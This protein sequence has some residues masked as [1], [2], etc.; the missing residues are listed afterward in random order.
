MGAPEITSVAPASR[1]AAAGADERLVHDLHG[2]LTVIRGLCATLARGAPR[3]DR[4]RD[5]ALIDAE[6]LRLAA[7]LEGL[8]RRVA[9]PARERR[10]ALALEALAVSV[11]ERHHGV[12]AQRGAL[13]SVRRHRGHPVVEADP[14]GLRR[15]LDNLVQ[16]ALRH[17]AREVRIVVG[18]RGDLA[19]VLV[20]DD[21]PG[22]RPEDRERIF[23]PRDRGS[24]PMGP[25]RGLGLAIA[26]EIARAHGG[27]LTLDPVGPGASFRLTLPLCG[28]PVTEP[29]AA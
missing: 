4:R 26:R 8:A 14:A 22:V 18:V 15:V 17:C 28:G 13:L 27:R 1:E 19:Q 10:R 9:R 29:R 21:G 12:A 6:A 16:N 20:R 24:A 23:W 5:L 7:G 3:A 2:P 25:G 11:A